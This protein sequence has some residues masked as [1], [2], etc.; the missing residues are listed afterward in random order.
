MIVGVIR[1]KPVLT[2]ASIVCEGMLAS[3][4]FGEFGENFTFRIPHAAIPHFTN[5]LFPMGK[6]NKFTFVLI[7][8]GADAVNK[9]LHFA[10][11]K[12]CHC[13]CL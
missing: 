3:V 7:A 5:S 9:P 6:S 12:K 2:H 11:Y 4:K 8:S 13:V 1:R 10:M